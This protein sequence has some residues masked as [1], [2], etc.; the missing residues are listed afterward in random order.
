MQIQNSEFRIITPSAGKAGSSPLKR[1]AIFACGR[2]D[3]S[4]SLCC[5]QNDTGDREVMQKYFIKGIDF[6]NIFDKI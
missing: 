4:T 5:A 2:G 3:S 6:Q 1:G